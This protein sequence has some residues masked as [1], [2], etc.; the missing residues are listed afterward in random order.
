VEFLVFGNVPTLCNY[1]IQSKTFVP[2]EKEAGGT[3]GNT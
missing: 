3:E 1:D 2:W